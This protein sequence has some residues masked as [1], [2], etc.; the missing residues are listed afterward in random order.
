V[1]VERAAFS[2]VQ[3]IM[4]IRAADANRRTV[5][6]S[7]W[8]FPG[9]LYFCSECGTVYYSRFSKNAKGVYRY[10][11]CGCPMAHGKRHWPNS[12]T[13]R[14]HKLLTEIVEALRGV[15]AV[16]DTFVERR[17]RGRRSSVRPIGMRPQRC[18]RRSRHLRESPRKSREPA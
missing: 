11:T 3:V 9:F 4:R 1:I 18:G 17:W 5:G 12:G 10:Y 13:V 2:G 15:F 6:R 7:N 14:Q 16:A 8:R